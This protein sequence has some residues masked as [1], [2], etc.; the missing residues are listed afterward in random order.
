MNKQFEF[1]FKK[2]E[3]EEELIGKTLE[4]EIPTKEDDEKLTI[5]E[6]KKPW[7]KDSE[8]KNLQAA[9]ETLKKVREM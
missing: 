8:E 6:G 2:K 4:G 5:S 1:P 9:E 3:G 7:S